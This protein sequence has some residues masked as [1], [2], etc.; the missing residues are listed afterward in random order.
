M[1]KKTAGYSLIEMSIVLA[2]L[3]ILMLFCVNLTV[4]RKKNLLINE[5][6]ALQFEFICLQRQ[7][8]SC[9]MSYRINFLLDQQAYEI[10]QIEK[11]VLCKLPSNIKFG[12]I[13]GIKGPP[14]K[15][16]TVIKQPIRFE[17]PTPLAAI[18]QPHGRISS[19]TVYLTHIDETIMGALSITPHQTAYMRVYIL[20]KKKT[21]KLLDT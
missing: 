15:P 20:E 14:G 17:N 12:F 2:A 5:L 9:N 6:R 16:E 10:V 3:F 18:I 8:I 11:K 13:S 7:V 21:W 4:Q 1:K 19:G